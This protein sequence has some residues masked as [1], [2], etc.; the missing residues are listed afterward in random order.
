V[1]EVPAQT[2][3]AQAA[4]APKPVTAAP[5]PEASAVPEGFVRIPGG[6][7]IETAW[8]KATP[9]LEARMEQVTRPASDFFC[10]STEAPENQ[11]MLSHYG[12]LPYLEEGEPW[13]V[14]EVSGE[15]A[16]PLEFVFQVFQDEEESIALP[17]GVK[18]LQCFLLAPDESAIDENDC[19]DGEDYHYQSGYGDDRGAYRIILRKS[20]TGIPARL[21]PPAGL[22]IRPYASIETEREQMIPERSDLRIL[23]PKTEKVFAAIESAAEEPS[24]APYWE[25]VE[26]FDFT[27]PDLE[28]YLGGYPYRVDDEDDPTQGWK[29]L[30]VWQHLFQLVIG[31]ESEH[32]NADNENS[33]PLSITS[34]Y[35]VNAYYEPNTGETYLFQMY[36]QVVVNVE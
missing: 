3:T 11:A 32:A 12:G 23:C 14:S 19:Y 16:Q 29:D 4:V 2:Q 30:G 18:L 33:D 31:Y 22:T 25:M 5:K 27:I 8:S 17:P 35:L 6:T 36:H 7:L 24:A 1:A 10:E 34:Y 26:K 13:P 20:I 9:K 21:H 15:S 28:S